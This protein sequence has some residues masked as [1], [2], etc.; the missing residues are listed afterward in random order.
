MICF[1]CQSYG[2]YIEKHG[3]AFF[4]LLW[5]DIRLLKHLLLKSILHRSYLSMVNIR[6]IP[7]TPGTMTSPSMPQNLKCQSQNKMYISVKL[8][9]QRFG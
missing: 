5:Y 4:S 1:K 9:M 8:Y 2:F 3:Y 7:F 6:D